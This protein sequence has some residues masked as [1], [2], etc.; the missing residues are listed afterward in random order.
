MNAEK[1][2]ELIEEAGY[3]VRS[4]SGRGMRGQ[5]CLA[6]Y[7]DNVTRV[8]LAVDVLVGHI[9][10]G[11]TT[12]TDELAEALKGMCTDQLGLGEIVYF[13]RFKLEAEHD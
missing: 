6:V 8:E 5:E 10:S 7:L 11:D 3:E 13:P 4:Y 1:F 2:Q 12:P 9:E